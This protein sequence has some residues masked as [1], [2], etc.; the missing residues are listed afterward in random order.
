MEEGGGGKG[1]ATGPEGVS[2]V[3]A[4]GVLVDW[5]VVLTVVV[6]CETVLGWLGGGAGW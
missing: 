4:V 2:A 6:L 1:A 3:G 5:T